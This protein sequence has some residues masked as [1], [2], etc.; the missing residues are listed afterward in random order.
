MKVCMKLNYLTIKPCDGWKDLNYL[1]SLSSSNILPVI[2]A[3][4]KAQSREW[5][6]ASGKPSTD[7]SSFQTDCLCECWQIGKSGVPQCMVF[8][9]YLWPRLHGP[10][11]QSPK[12]ALCFSL[13]QAF[14]FCLLFLWLL[15]SN[16]VPFPVILF[17]SSASVLELTVFNNLDV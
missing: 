4:T 10:R 17:L 14:W 9:S 6:I 7:S 3:V 1:S 15:C 2:T 12:I 8:A 5:K 13:I 16:F 11:S